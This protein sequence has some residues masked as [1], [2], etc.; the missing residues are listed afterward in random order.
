MFFSY[1]FFS[2]MIV[3]LQI[4]LKIIFV[5][6]YTYFYFVSLSSYIMGTV[7]LLLIH[8]SHLFI[9]SSKINYIIFH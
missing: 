9:F 8:L 2:K 1:V 7:Y 4:I 3:H 6:L 5:V